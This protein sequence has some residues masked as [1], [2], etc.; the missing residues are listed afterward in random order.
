M[1]DKQKSKQELIQECDLLRQWVA[2]PEQSELALKRAEQEL[3]RS[4]E[5]L[6]SITQG[7]PE[8][9]LLISKD[10][11]ILWANKAAMEAHGVLTSNYFGDRFDKSRE[12]LLPQ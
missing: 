1:T 8:N 9:I 3:G 5:M 2:G 7:I 11:K 4:R 6:E 10:F 12:G